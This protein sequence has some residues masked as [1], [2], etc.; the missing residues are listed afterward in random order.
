MDGRREESQTSLKVCSCSPSTRCLTRARDRAHQE[1]T[2]D[3]GGKR[4]TWFFSACVWA[5]GLDCPAT[6]ITHSRG[7]GEE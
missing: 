7:G 1:V 4:R 2:S 5:R 6:H 3:P